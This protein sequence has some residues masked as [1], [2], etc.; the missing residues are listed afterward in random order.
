MNGMKNLFSG[1]AAKFLVA[2][3]GVG[4]TLLTHFAAKWWE[5][6]AVAALAAL[7]VYFTPNTPKQ[8]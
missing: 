7:A 8:G 2:L 6:S 5:P 1:S 4:A 3:L